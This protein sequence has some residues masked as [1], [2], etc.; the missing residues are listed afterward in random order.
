MMK[1]K[2]SIQRTVKFNEKLNTR[3]T[4][5]PVEDVQELTWTQIAIDEMRFRQ[6]LE[7][8]LK[9]KIKHLGCCD[10]MCHDECAQFT[11]SV[12]RHDTHK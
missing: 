8:M 2:R 3:Y 5:E 6:P 12:E 10:K 1:T 7:L 9:E 11:S 4:Y